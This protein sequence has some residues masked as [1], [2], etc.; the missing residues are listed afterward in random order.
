MKERL[1]DIGVV[2]LADALAW[3]FSGVMLRGS[4]AAWDLRR[5]QPYEIYNKLVFNIPTGT[6]GD[7]FDRYAIRLEEMR[8]SLLIIYQCIT[9]LPLGD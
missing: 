4:G 6:K 3:G 9:K 8:Q 1:V 2:S 7:C 5:A